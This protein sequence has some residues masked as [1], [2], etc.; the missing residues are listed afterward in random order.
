MASSCGIPCDH[1]L[2]GA[3][4]RRGR[5]FTLGDPRTVA[6]VDQWLDWQ[7][8]HLAQAVRDLVG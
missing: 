1:A 2:S 8:A 7:A 5:A 3:A 4:R 6:L